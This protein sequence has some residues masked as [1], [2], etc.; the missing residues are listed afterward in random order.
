MPAQGEMTWFTKSDIE[1]TIRRV[2]ELR[3]SGILSGEGSRSPFF[4]SVLIELLICVNDLL[5]KAKALGVRVTDKRFLP[6]I[7][8]VNDVTDLV[9][10]CRNAACHISS[11]LKLFE[12]NKFSFCM[13]FGYCPNAIVMNDV[14][15]GCDFDDDAA[16][17]FGGYKL[18]LRRHL[19][20]AHEAAKAVLLPLINDTTSEVAR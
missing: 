14:A 16:L 10:C 19:M 15:I 17:L 18:Y 20:A 11:G 8:G 1:T 3:V 2:E 5:Q 13:F 9:N 4:Q 6:D 7:E 12:S